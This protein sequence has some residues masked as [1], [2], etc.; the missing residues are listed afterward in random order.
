MLT[1]NLSIFTHGL[2]HLSV[3]TTLIAVKVNALGTNKRQIT[4]D[5]TLS[6]NA[7]HG[8]NK[9]SIVMDFQNIFKYPSKNA[10]V[11][12]HYSRNTKKHYFLLS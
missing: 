3:S 2:F 4:A 9:V 12:F 11:R 7:P 1:V 8:N 5:I 10:K 6:S